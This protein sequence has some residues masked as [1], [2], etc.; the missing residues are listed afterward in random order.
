MN[1]PRVARRSI[2][3]AAVLVLSTT[4]HVAAQ[5][6]PPTPPQPPDPLAIPAPPPPLVGAFDAVADSAARLEFQAARQHTPFVPPTGDIK[7][8]GDLYEQ[9]RSAIERGQYEKALSSLDTLIA[10][11]DRKSLAASTANRVDAA[12]YWKAYS[13]AKQRQLAEAMTTL[14]EI[15]K[16]F[17][18]SRWLRDAMA[19]KMEVLQAS[20][21]TVSPDSQ[22]DEDLKLLALRG[23]MQSD[24]DRAVSMIE[25]VLG[26][27]SSLKVKENALFVLSQTR[28]AKAHEILGNVA[29]SGSNPDLQLRAIR[30]L[31]TMGGSGNAQILEDAYRASADESVKRAIIRSFMVSGNRPRLAAIANDTSSSASL[32]G[33]AIR[34]LGV[35]HA[36]DELA[37]LYPRESSPELKRRIVDGLFVA[38]SA[39]RLVELARAEKDMSLK[40]DIVQRLSLM[41]SKD[42]TDYLVEL[43]K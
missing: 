8:G 4:G 41:K 5:A 25:G 30:Y 28:S 14:E 37:R 15:Q 23:L 21:Q 17:A 43:L 1:M 29:R 35:M 9:A 31:G 10:R 39:G 13:Q 20:G 36:D 11:F 32:R 24:P 42:A 19:L 16:R 40:K 7:I 2:V 22:T 3:A 26:G 33:E 12:L 6:V 27:N 18:D 34:Q 38:G